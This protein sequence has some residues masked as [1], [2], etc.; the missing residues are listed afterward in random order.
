MTKLELKPGFNQIINSSH[1]L[2]NPVSDRQIDQEIIDLH[3]KT[4]YYPSFDQTDTAQRD[5]FVNLPMSAEK[6]YL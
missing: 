2:P 1:Q 4:G 5:N 3:L 6:E